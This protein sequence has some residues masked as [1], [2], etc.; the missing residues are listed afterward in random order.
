MVVEK[1]W[2]LEFKYV[3]IYMPKG[4]LETKG[5][6]QYGGQDEESLELHLVGWMQ[7]CRS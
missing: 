5:S 7:Y 4:L 3:L 2:D 1:T 6:R